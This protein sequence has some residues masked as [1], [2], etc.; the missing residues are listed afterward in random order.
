MLNQ[1]SVKNARRE[2]LDCINIR[3]YQNHSRQ[4]KFEGDVVVE[5]LM[6][7]RSW[8]MRRILWTEEYLYFKRLEEENIIDLIPLKEIDEIV[9][10]SDFESETRRNIFVKRTSGLNQDSSLQATKNSKPS[11][12]QKLR[13]QNAF[14][15][16]F[17][18]PFCGIFGDL[19]IAVRKSDTKDSRQQE[20]PIIHIRTIPGTGVLSSNPVWNR[21]R[22][23][24]RHFKQK[25]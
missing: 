16:I 1:I 21:S 19:S 20:T 23:F 6:L 13:K 10:A 18:L 22:K 11:F 2:S 17:E 5:T 3:L 8:Q 24:V 12:A 25:C 14:Q 9:C 15:N 4:E 7:D